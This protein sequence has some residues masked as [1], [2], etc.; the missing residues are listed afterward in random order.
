M[1]PRPLPDVAGLRHPADTA[2]RSFAPPR[3]RVG[4]TL[5]RLSS[6]PSLI[7]GSTILLFYVV[8]ALVALQQ[9]F[10]H[11]GSL[12]LDPVLATNPFPPGPSAAHPFGEMSGIGVDEFR[13]LLQATPWDLAMFGGILCIGPVVGAVLG[14]YAGLRAGLV[15]ETVSSVS[16]LVVAVPPFFLVWVVVLNLDL[17]V[18]PSDFVLIFIVIFAGTLT[19]GHARAVLSAARIISGQPF[20][21]AARANGASDT[22]VLLRHVLPN[23][24]S[25][26][27]AQVPVDVFSI[28]FLLTAFPFVGC[29]D[30]QQLQALG[31]F[32]FAT[33]FPTAPFPEW[34][35]LLASGACYGLNVVFPLTTWWMWFFPTLTIVL[36]AAGVTLTSEGVQR[37]L[38][39][40]G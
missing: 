2:P 6:I 1:R 25:A 15:R 29:V 16:D 9:D 24:F 39:P 12:T 14:A 32:T 10:G 3:R 20:V 18:P 34:G 27:L 31:S 28:V 11:L 23:S 22:R 17:V 13:A 19:W 21:E 26:V 5:A 30:V 8:V 4:P 7:V 38:L 37:Y 35:S 36:F 40:R 33:P